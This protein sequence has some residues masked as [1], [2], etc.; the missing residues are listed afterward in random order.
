MTDRIGSPFS[1][2][3]MITDPKRFFGR[4]RQKQQIFNQLASPK[5][6]SV[7]IIGPKRIGRSSL[8]KHIEQSYATHLPDQ[9]NYTFGYL[10]LASDT[11]KT[12]NQF[13]G[14]VA[15]ELFAERFTELSPQAFDDKLIMADASGRTRYILLLDEFNVLQRRSETFDDDFY[16]GLRSRLNAQSPK[17]AIVLASHLRLSEVAIQNDFTS[18]F[19]GIFYS[20]ELGDF[21]EEEARQSVLRPGDYRLTETDLS[22]I[23]TWVDPQ[24]SGRYHPLQ[25]NIGANLVWMAARPPS[26]ATLQTEFESQVAHALGKDV[27]TLRQDAEAQAVDE[28]KRQSR[29]T[30]RRETFDWWFKD[31]PPIKAVLYTLAAVVLLG[32][33][34]SGAVTV[35]Q[36]LGIVPR[37]FGIP[38]ETPTP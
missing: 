2:R 17:M 36:L 34:I 37:I 1:D 7:A 24:K 9:A 35:G 6:Q 25:L 13:Y 23:K 5:P 27:T 16:D 4:Q 30:Q 12:P 20:I 18:T 19:F 22:Q 33:L 28:E 10:D 14:A 3:S 31:I 26:Y 11:V 15:T 29:R 21:S 38:T 8:L 32:L